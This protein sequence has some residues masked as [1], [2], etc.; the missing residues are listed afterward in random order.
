MPPAVILSFGYMIVRLV[1]QLVMLAMRAEHANEV[2]I[3]VLRHQVAVLRRQV[4]RPDLEPAD[5]AVLAALSRL[6]PRPRW[7]TFFVTPATLLRWHRDLVARRWTYPRR[8]PGRPS[9]SD[10]IRALVLRLAA[11]NAGW[12]HRRIHGELVGLG[13]QISASTVWKIL[14][15]AGVDPVPRRNGPTWTQ[16]LTGQANAILACDFLHVE[17]IGLKR[18]YVLFVME[19]STRRVHILGATPNPDSGWVTQQV[20]NLVMELGDRVGQ[21][22][23]LICDRDTKYRGSF[24]AVFIAQGIRMVRTPPRAPR[25]KQVVSYCAPCG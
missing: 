15:T 10:E 25:A 11:E 23:F 24:D 1:L 13:H 14:H 2:E 9:V 22:R 3:M 5:R 18:I 12:G 8:R 6:L 21:F 7:S 16:F 4:A 20:R 19:I 17:T